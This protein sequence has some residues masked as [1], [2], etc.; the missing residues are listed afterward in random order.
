[1]SA[2]SVDSSRTQVL[3]LRGVRGA[4]TPTATT[5][6]PGTNEIDDLRRE[7]RE[8]RELLAG[9]TGRMQAAPSKVLAPGAARAAAPEP[10]AEASSRMSRRGLL[11]ALPAA[12]AVGVGTT[13]GSGL[14]GAGSAAA[15]EGAP[16]LMGRLNDGG[17]KPTQLVSTATETLVLGDLEGV[18]VRT[19]LAPSGIAISDSLFGSAHLSIRSTAWPY[20]WDAFLEV[21][22]EGAPFVSVQGHVS[23]GRDDTGGDAMAVTTQGATAVTASVVSGSA[24]D[25][26]GQVPP[27]S[28]PGTALRAN[29]TTDSAAV[30]VNSEA[31]RAIEST[32]SSTT[33]KTDAVVVYNA[34]LGRGLIATNTN[35]ASAMSTVTGVNNG[36][37]AGV[38][39]ATS[40]ANPSPA[41]VGWAGAKGRGGRFKGGAAAVNLAPSSAPSHPV[42]GQIGD[43]F[44]DSTGRLWFCKGTTTWKQLA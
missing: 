41:V 9:L 42:S 14:L 1:M 33:T 21:G 3:D 27:V 43:L 22:A 37:A 4:S 19:S 35:E 8:L 29:A 5:G 15:A 16:L 26:T 20:G 23:N 32:T 40:D 25:W 7:V 28:I 31:G 11:R 17:A 36:K 12:A 44:L 18:P 39:G 6:T 34:G 2:N 10:V 24:G 30:R 13:V 38:W